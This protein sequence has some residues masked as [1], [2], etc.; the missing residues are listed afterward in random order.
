[1]GKKGK[2]VDG[3]TAIKAAQR[4]AREARAARGEPPVVAPNAPE[5]TKKT[6]SKKTTGVRVHHTVMPTKYEVVCYAC[7][8]TFQQTGRSKNTTCPKCKKVL[9]F[10]D[11]KINGIWNKELKTAGKVIVQPDG[12]VTGGSIFAADLVLKGK[13]TGGEATIYRRLEVEENGQFDPKCITAKDLKVKKNATVVLQKASFHHVDIAGTL[14]ANLTA[15]GLVHIKPSGVLEGSLTA[16]H[17]V[18]DDGGGLIGSIH[19]TDDTS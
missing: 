6:S 19:L 15:T 13:V 16:Q 17:L 9:D 1:M 10:V 3:F 5:R 12:I 2:Y 14:K 11:H 4:A 7:G 18:M 8:Y